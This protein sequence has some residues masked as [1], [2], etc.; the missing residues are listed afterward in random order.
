[1]RQGAIG[2]LD[3]AGVA[4]ALW[5]RLE[6][7]DWDGVAATLHD[8]LVLDWPQSGERIRG[9]EDFLAVNR[10]YPGEWHITLERVVAAA[11]EVV[12]LVRVEFADEPGRLDRAASFM[13]VRD[14]R[15]ASI[16]EFWPDPFPA[17]EWRRP[18]VERLGP[19]S[20]SPASG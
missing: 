19:T 17:A 6:A 1:M 12:T 8:D 18:W 2:E 13:R 11:D 9:P 10:A 4:R 5:E 20:R 15:I 3:P 14:V 16:V 7:R